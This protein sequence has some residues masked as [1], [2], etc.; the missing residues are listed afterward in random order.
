MHPRKEG[1]K[2]ALSGEKAKLTGR[3]KGRANFSGDI[4]FR[5]FPLPYQKGDRGVA[6]RR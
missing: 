6:A 5:F 3:A 4:R 2:S 1:M